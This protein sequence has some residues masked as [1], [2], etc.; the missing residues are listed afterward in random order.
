MP[1]LLQLGSDVDA[2]EPVVAYGLGRRLRGAE[3]RKL[4]RALDGD[5]HLRRAATA[6]A[7]RLFE[8]QGGDPGDLQSF[9]EWL[10]AHADE[11]IAFVQKI[12]ALF[13]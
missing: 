13:T 10:L 7:V 5:R 4:R 2:Y 3:H 6:E 8:E 1:E 12:I 9:M 11:I